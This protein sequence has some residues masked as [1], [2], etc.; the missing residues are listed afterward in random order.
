MTFVLKEEEEK[1]QYF[2]DKQQQEE[3]NDI[4]IYEYRYKQNRS[5]M[6]QIHRTFLDWHKSYKEIHHH[7]E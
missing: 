4:Y 6:N 3:D 2:K 7:P 1:N 5:F